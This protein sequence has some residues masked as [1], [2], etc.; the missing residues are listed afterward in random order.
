ME[1]H[2]NCPVL[3]DFSLKR[4]PVEL[5]YANRNLS[6]SPRP[7]A[8]GGPCD[9][10]RERGREKKER[11]GQIEE[12][13]REEN[14]DDPFHWL[15]DTVL[16]LRGCFD[17]LTTKL[18]SACIIELRSRDSNFP[19]R[20][21]VIKLAGWKETK[22]SWF[23]FF[24]F[25]FRA[26]TRGGNRLKLRRIVRGLLDARETSRCLTLPGNCLKCS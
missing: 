22:E 4:D 6:K 2:C 9:E 10:W 8:A 3:L 19:S 15:R 17:G 25:V 20:H 7:S 23:S 21:F 1:F 11:N 12:E 5:H 26:R 18:W 13:K 14:L 16:R 24:F